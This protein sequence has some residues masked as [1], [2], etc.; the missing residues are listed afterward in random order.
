[1]NFSL[2]AYQL[3]GYSDLNAS[4]RVIDRSKKRGIAYYL[5]GE[6]LPRSLNFYFGTATFFI[7]VLMMAIGIA[8][9]VVQRLDFIVSVALISEIAL[10]IIDLCCWERERCAGSIDRRAIGV[11]VELVS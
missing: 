9:L 8:N 3:F 5:T 2:D 10:V 7:G 6:C 11:T 4:E 1:V